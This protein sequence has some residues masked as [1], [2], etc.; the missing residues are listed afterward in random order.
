MVGRMD[1]STLTERGQV[2]IPA[3]LRKAMGLRTGDRLAFTAISASEMRVTVVAQ[4]PP[5]GPLAMLGY[6]RGRFKG[7]PERTDEWMRE[8]REGEQ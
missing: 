3:S 4:V 8:I 2:S 5:P 6:G 7:C 1:S